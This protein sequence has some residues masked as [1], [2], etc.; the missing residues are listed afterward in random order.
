MRTLMHVTGSSWRISR[1]FRRYANVSRPGRARFAGIAMRLLRTEDDV[2]ER[3]SGCGWSDE[4]E[5]RALDDV[6]NG[7]RRSI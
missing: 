1:G 2:A 3:Y 4:I 7:N 6:F 5:R